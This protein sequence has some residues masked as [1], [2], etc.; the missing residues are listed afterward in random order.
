MIGKWSGHFCH[1][2]HV[3]M[4]FG[5]YLFQC[6]LES[7]I[8]SLRI[9]AEENRTSG[10]KALE[11]LPPL[12]ARLKSCPSTNL[13][14]RAPDPCCWPFL[15][16]VCTQHIFTHHTLSSRACRGTLCFA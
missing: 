8:Q 9:P 1:S 11:I 12:T 10:A 4:Q 6:E 16:I 3:A 15:L 5:L 7:G 13:A 2:L 14:L